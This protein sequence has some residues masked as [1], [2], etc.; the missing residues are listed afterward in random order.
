M[1]FGIS[2]GM[3]LATQHNGDIIIPQPEKDVAPG[4]KIS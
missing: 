4:S 3:V 2:N 1:K